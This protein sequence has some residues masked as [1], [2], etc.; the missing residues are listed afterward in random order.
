EAVFGDDA[1]R[2]LAAQ[3]KERLTARV[4]AVLRGQTARY[5]AQLDALG[6]DDVRGDRLRDAARDVA[7]AAQQERATRSR[8]DDGL[9][10][11]WSG[12][13]LRGAGTFR[14]PTSPEGIP[15]LPGSLAGREPAAQEGDAG[16]PDVPDAPRARFWRR[17]RRKDQ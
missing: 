6:T 1:V 12:G 10:R 4:D 17:W 11:P 5:P 14:P 7:E 16:A 15:G 8:A 13:M 3:A 9:T 2:R